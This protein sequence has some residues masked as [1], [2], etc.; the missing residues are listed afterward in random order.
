[1]DA[2]KFDSG[3]ERLDRA[4]ADRLAK[5]RA[6]PVDTTGLDRFIR[7]AIPA[8]S[9]G[10]AVLSMRWFRPMRAVAASFLVVAVIA[11]I[12]LSMSGQPVEA[13]TA[14]MAQ[15]HNDLVSGR[16]PVTRVDS[17]QDAN[18]AISAQWSQSP[19]MPDMP[20]DHVMACCMR[21]VKD[22][23]MA[24]VLFQGDG[25]P[26]SMTVANASDMKIPTSPVITHNGIEYHVQSVGALNMVMTQ[27]NGRWVCLIAKLPTDR[28]MDLASSL[29]F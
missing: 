29:Q 10:R 6:M 3:D 20:K 16:V 12:L 5:L 14:E 18:Q 25:E 13:S 2:P 24:C 8:P 4:T 9:T 23:K 17:I 21:S 27:R 1:M 19:K 15:F 11:G 26:V 22:R 28:L 7:A